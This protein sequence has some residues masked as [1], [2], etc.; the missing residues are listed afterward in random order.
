MCLVYLGGC[1]E[2]KEKQNK[3]IKTRITETEYKKVKKYCKE[4]GVFISELI[5]IKLDVHLL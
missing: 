1:H 3:M 2:K 5:R 4:Q